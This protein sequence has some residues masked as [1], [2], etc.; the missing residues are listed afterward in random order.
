MRNRLLPYVLIS[1]NRPDFLAFAQEA[2]GRDGLELG[3][4]HFDGTAVDLWIE[5]STGRISGIEHVGR[6]PGA[7]MGKVSLTC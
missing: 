5:A 7:F 1:R 4:A 6:G 3:K 2:P